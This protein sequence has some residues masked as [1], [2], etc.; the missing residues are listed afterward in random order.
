M[1]FPDAGITQHL[2]KEYREKCDMV[3]ID[4]YEKY[5]EKLRESQNPK[6]VLR[7]GSK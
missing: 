4:P 2:I 1:V 7:S 3:I 6:L 5:L